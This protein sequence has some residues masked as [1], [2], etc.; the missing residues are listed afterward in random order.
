[1]NKTARARMSVP[2]ENREHN[3]CVVVNVVA[4]VVAFNLNTTYTK[5]PRVEGS[6]CVNGKLSACEANTLK[7]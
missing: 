3:Q 2:V 7:R 5:R 1:M 4:V 6:A